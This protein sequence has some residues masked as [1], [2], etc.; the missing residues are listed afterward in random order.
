MKDQNSTELNLKEIFKDELEKW[1][2]NNDMWYEGW[3][4]IKTQMMKY[5]F[6]ITPDWGD[7]KGIQEFFMAFD[8]KA[9][10][11][12]I[13]KMFGPKSVSRLPAVRDKELYVELGIQIYE[14][15]GTYDLTKKQFGRV[16]KPIKIEDNEMSE[17]KK[18]AVKK[19]TVAKKATP[20]KKVSEKK[21]AGGKR[22]KFA[23]EDSSKIVLVKPELLKGIRPESNRGIVSAA[24]P[25]GAGGITFKN[26]MA[27]IGRKVAKDDVVTVLYALERGSKKAIKVSE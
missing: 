15:L 23:L 4:E 12:V 16:V 6:I 26:L 11:H 10:E 21:E 22:K 24:I 18:V 8:T 20:V 13:T 2:G 14:I 19:K 17:E 7:K 1:N 27:K 5:G 9:M 3:R 25:Q